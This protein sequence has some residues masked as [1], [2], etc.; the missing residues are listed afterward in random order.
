MTLTLPAESGATIEEVAAWLSLNEGRTV[1]VAE[2]RQIEGRALR[3]LRAEFMRR[4]LSAWAVDP[5]EV[6]LV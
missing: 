4:G 2:V 6:A 1:T 3:K 5:R